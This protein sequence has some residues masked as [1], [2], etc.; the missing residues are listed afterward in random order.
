M[1]FPLES[2]DPKRPAG[3]IQHVGIVYNILQQ[4]YHLYSGWDGNH[5]ATQQV[6][7]VNAVTGACFLIRRNL[8][9]NLKGFSLDYGKG[10]FEDL[11]LC[12]R[13]RMSGFSIRV[14][15]QAVVYHQA[16]LSVIAAGEGYPMERN[17]Q[18][19]KA[20]FGEVIPYDDWLTAGLY[21]E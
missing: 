16:N 11:D 4:P 10:T 19:F 7:D 9:Q 14:L 1:L 15:P 2:T 5:P 18:I 12:T 8:W 21:Y 20:K 13:T 17:A 3:K 6:R